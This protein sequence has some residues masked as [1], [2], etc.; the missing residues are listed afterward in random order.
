MWNDHAQRYGLEPFD[1]DGMNPDQ[2]TYSALRAAL[3]GRCLED[4]ERGLARHAECVW[5]L[6]EFTSLYYLL[7]TSPTYGKRHLWT[8]ADGDRKP[9]REQRTKGCKTPQAPVLWRD[10]VDTW[11]TVTDWREAPDL[12]NQF[13][14]DDTAARYCAAMRKHAPEVWQAHRAEALER[15]QRGIDGGKTTDQ[16]AADYAEQ[17]SAFVKAFNLSPLLAP[18][19]DAVVKE[20]TGGV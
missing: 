7:R 1:Y 20:A 10:E 5:G 4:F 6:A 3:R 17:R 18:L 14:D 15:L 9:Q 12:T 16:L 2:R 19:M 13:H 11:L 8:Y